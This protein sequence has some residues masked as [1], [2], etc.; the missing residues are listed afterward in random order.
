MHKSMACR[1][2]VVIMGVSSYGHRRMLPSHQ[3]GK[4][5]CMRAGVQA[6]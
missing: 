2:K 3:H 1:G 6:G 5:G 4:L